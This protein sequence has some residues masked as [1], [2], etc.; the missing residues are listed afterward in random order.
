MATDA[1]VV[2]FDGQRFQTIRSPHIGIVNR[3]IQDRRRLLVRHLE[4]R[5]P[6]PAGHHTTESADHQRPRRSG[7][8]QTGSDRSQRAP[9][10]LVFEFKGMSFRTH[11]DDMLYTWKL[12]GHDRDWQSAVHQRMARYEDLPA[13]EYTFRVKAL[14]RDLNESA[15][16]RVHLTVSPDPLL[17]GLNQALS[18]SGAG[19]EFIGDSATLQIVQTQLIEVAPSD[20][21]VLILGE[22]GT[23]KGLAARTVHAFSARPS[24]PF[25]QVN[26]G[27]LPGGLVESELFGHEKGAFTGA[28]ARRLGKVELAA[29]GT[30]FLDEIGDMSLEAQV[31]LLRLLEEGFFERV[32]GTTTQHSDAR[33]IAA[34]NRDLEGMVAAGTFRKDL[35]YRLRVFPVRLPSLRDRADDIPL[36][37]TYFMEKM[38]THVGKRLTRLSP[39]ALVALRGYRWPGN[40]RELEHVIGRAVVVCRDTVIRTEDFGLEVDPVAAVAADS[41]FAG[42]TLAQVERAH[43]LRTLEDCDWVVAGSDGAAVRLGLKESTLRFRM[44]KLDIL[45]P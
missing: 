31:K 22:T 8:R 20:L 36:L 21:T 13:G 15:A 43:I 12:A 41:D 17:E 7:S 5:R 19:G 24:G 18:Q 26:C 14:D 10:Q 25:I 30:L 27:A 40:V 3:I 11:P 38:A 2:H 35:Y 1:G 42:L 34:T 9:R 44:K 28:H 37:A 4:R 32:G 16:A 39:E 45:R 6:L 29:G 33:V 23:G